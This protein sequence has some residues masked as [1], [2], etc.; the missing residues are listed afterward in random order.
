MAISG[1]ILV[2]QVRF[3]DRSRWRLRVVGQVSNATV[4]EVQAKLAALF[5]ISA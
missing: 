4:A 3:I 5:G 2:D 1:A